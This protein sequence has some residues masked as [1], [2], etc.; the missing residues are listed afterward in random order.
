MLPHHLITALSSFNPSVQRR[1]LT[2][3]GEKR[4]NRGQRAAGTTMP[5]EQ[6]EDSISYFLLCMLPCHLITA[7]SSFLQSLRT[8]STKRGGQRGDRGGGNY[9][10]VNA[11]GI[12]WECYFAP[13]YF[14]SHMLPHHLITF[15]L[16]FSILHHGVGRQREGGDVGIVVGEQRHYKQAEGIR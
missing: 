16:H 5:W 13:V 14:V 2:K 15:P 9:N 4:T 6:G 11:K 12:R 10:A 7:L 3:R 8:A 1:A